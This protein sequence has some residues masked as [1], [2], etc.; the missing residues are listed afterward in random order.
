V[1]LLNTLEERGEKNGVATLCHGT[2]G[3]TAMAI[4]KL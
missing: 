4:E 3:A 2:G 1:T